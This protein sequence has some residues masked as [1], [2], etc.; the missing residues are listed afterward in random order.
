MTRASRDAARGLGGDTGPSCASGFRFGTPHR[1][2]ALALA[3]SA[4]ACAP[5]ARTPEAPNRASLG[6]CYTHAPRARTA[7]GQRADVAYD[8]WL[9]DRF[10]LGVDAEYASFARERGRTE[11][12]VGAGLR[13]AFVLDLAE[14]QPRAGVRFA[15]QRWTHDDGTRPSQP[16]VLVPFGG[17]DWAPRNL[18][19]IVGAEIQGT[20]LVSLGDSPALPGLA[21]GLRTGVAF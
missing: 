11:A 6:A 14:L 17:L 12:L 19:L 9:D 10:L 13:L 5:Y 1:T 4:T 21:Y 15:L 16:A 18:P 3:F 2:V 7:D 8:R 20:P